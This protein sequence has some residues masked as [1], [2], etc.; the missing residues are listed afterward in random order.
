MGDFNLNETSAAKGENEKLNRI[1]THR[2]CC[3]APSW[4]RAV[5][6]FRTVPVLET[7]GRPFF[8]H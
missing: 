7:N 6:T 3:I 4:L 8:K 2:E 5:D 1:H